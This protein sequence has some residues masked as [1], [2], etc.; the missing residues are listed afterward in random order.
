MSDTDTSAS[1]HDA[2]LKRP[3]AAMKRPAMARGRGRGRARGRGSG[4]SHEATMDSTA[5]AAVVPLMPKHD[6]G[7][8]A[9]E[10][11]SASEETRRIRKAEED[12]NA[13]GKGAKRAK[14]MQDDSTDTESAECLVEQSDGPK[15]SSA[16][17]FC[18]WIMDTKVDPEQFQQ[19]V[20]RMQDSQAITMGEFCAGMC[21]GTMAASIVQQ[22]IQMKSGGMSIASLV[23]W[24]CFGSNFVGY[25][26][27]IP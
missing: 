5:A 1:H 14:A 25:C 10:G 23:P 26:G 21:S 20:L 12:W 2:P 19:V 18:K 15:S 24:N 6:E 13:G 27:Q 8:A 22:V 4:P 11:T 17:A 7:D 9:S 16:S 3:S